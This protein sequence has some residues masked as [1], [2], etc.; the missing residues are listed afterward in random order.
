MLFIVMLGGKHPKA[1]IEVHDVV[2]VEGQSLEACYPA[3]QALW[4]G[5]SKGLHID[6]WM[7]VDGVDGYKIHFADTPAPAG[8]PAL[9]LLNFGGY[10]KGEFGEEHRYV[11]QVAQ[12]AAK[13]KALGKAN[14]P[15]KWLKPHTDAVIDIDECIALTK[16]GARYLHLVPAEH[17]PIK[18]ASDYIVLSSN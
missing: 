16:V 14:Y 18:Q 9:F 17:G 8:A 3:L 6:S 4:F 2:C 11:L 5:A 13:A 10:T 7:Q 12:D 1:T 15:A